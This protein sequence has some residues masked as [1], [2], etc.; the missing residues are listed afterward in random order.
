[1]RLASLTLGLTLAG[2]SGGEGS[3]EVAEGDTRP[4]P[5]GTPE[6][7]F[8]V[9][10][11]DS[12]RLLADGTNV[13][14]WPPTQ[15]D[16]GGNGHRAL[17]LAL[18]DVT[19]DTVVFVLPGPTTFQDA[20]PLLRS[21]ASAGLRSQWLSTS[22]AGP[23][24][25]PVEQPALLTDTAGLR[26]VGARPH[27]VLAVTQRG[28]AHWVEG[29]VAFEALALP[30][31]G[32]EPVALKA[33][34]LP[35]AVDCAVVFAADPAL[36][37]ACQDGLDPDSPDLPDLT[38][39]TSAGCLVPLA[40]AE[41]E[42]QAWPEALAANLQQLDLSGW[43]TPVAALEPGVSLTAASQLLAGFQAA[44]STL[45]VL[46]GTQGLQSDE[47][48]PPCAT[49]APTAQELAHTGA[50][51]LG[52]ASRE[53]AARERAARA[54]EA[55]IAMAE[56]SREE[57]LEVPPYEAEITEVE[58]TG[59][60]SR[61]TARTVLDAAWDSLDAC[62]RNGARVG[63]SGTVRLD[64]D[65]HPDG[66]VKKVRVVEATPGMEA[67]SA[68]LRGRTRRVRFPDSGEASLLSYEVRLLSL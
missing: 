55:R 32:G 27:L 38:V 65:I 61:G 39:G 15:A 18:A 44:G 23:A 29:L 4:L 34:E 54:R 11:D 21:A 53:A 17:D 47:A 56:A 60:P 63:A 68:C 1:M 50:H 8:P 31:G 33:S 40:D 24:V 48:P 43:G 64:V 13:S 12:G 26:V 5:E 49:G 10:V 46:A 67:T 2:C 36:A 19:G 51:W 41:G 9:R 6:G 57:A 22:A 37:A 20:E 7:A 16:L 45:P 66:R 28:G 3:G 25:G 30:E 14:A 35:S 59:G 58:I 52:R 62:F 42:L